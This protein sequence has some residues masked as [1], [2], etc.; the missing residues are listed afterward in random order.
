M[1]ILMR[2]KGRESDNEGGVQTFKLDGHHTGQG[3][4]QKFLTASW[5]TQSVSYGQHYHD[6]RDVLIWG[7]LSE[8]S[9][10]LLLCA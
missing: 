10:M 8:P 5:G 4:H 9:P 1:N 3:F 6:C 2:G 7:N